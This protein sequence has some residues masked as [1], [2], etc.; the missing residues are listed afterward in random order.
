MAI[1]K[2]FK[3]V[4]L[5]QQKQKKTDFQQKQ[6]KNE[7]HGAT[8]V[9]PHSDYPY[10]DSSRYKTQKPTEIDSPPLCGYNYIFRRLFPT[11]LPRQLLS[12]LKGLRAWCRCMKAERQQLISLKETSKA[13]SVI[14]GCNSKADRCRLRFYRAG[15][16]GHKWE[17]GQ[18]AKARRINAR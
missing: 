11:L 14:P 6:K 1:R 3:T 2:Y 10:G 17:K 12:T 7:F 15:V 18:R 4:Y 13:P 5:I 16:P 9:F 8:Q